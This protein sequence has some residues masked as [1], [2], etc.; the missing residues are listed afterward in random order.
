MKAK[1]VEIICAL[2]KAGSVGGAAELLGRTQPA[3]TKALKAVESE[4][5]CQIFNRNAFG[6][7]P[8]VEG[9][10]IVERCKR[11]QVDL[12]LLEQDVAQIQGDFRGTISVVVSPLTAVKI[13]P[14]VVRRYGKRFPDVRVSIT[15]GHDDKAFRSLKERT[16][17]FVIGPIPASGV[18]A[19]YQVDEVL[20]TTVRA[21]CAKGSK[22]ATEKDPVVLQKARWGS[23]GPS[24][25]VPS[26]NSFF[27]NQGFFPPTPVVNSDSILSILSLI[28]QDDIICTLPTHFYE[29]IADRWSLHRLNL[30]FEFPSVPIAIV[31]D[32]SRTP[33][34]AGLAFLDFVKEE[35]TRL[36]SVK[37]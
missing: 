7:V 3:M 5:G 34:L 2:S 21:F 6:I 1:H 16:A 20:R 30:N 8:T 17:D 13:M 24:D 25:R 22:Y 19:S 23:I 10:R 4:I 15:G 32:R 18:D 9:A 33:T 37:T 29:A 28:E 36:T 27:E 11:I 35:F 14:N 31:T 12:D 26:Y